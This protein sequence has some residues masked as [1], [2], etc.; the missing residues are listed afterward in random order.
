MNFENWTP[1]DVILVDINHNVIRTFP[2]SGN[3]CRMDLERKLKCR[4][5]NI[6]CYASLSHGMTNIP[7]AVRGTYFIVSTFVRVASGRGDFISP[8]GFIRDE[9][10][11]II[12]CTSFD[13]N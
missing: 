3:V 12:G 13:I 5:D 11:K 2:A 4:L 10:G 8:A 9:E 1:H 6:D 7:R